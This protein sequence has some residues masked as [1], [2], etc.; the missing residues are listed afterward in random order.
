MIQPNLQPT[1]PRMGFFVTIVD[2]FKLSAIVI[3]SPIRKTEGVLDPLLV[4]LVQA[5]LRVFIIQ[6][7]QGELCNV[8]HSTHQVLICVTRTNAIFAEVIQVQ[9][10]RFVSQKLHLTWQYFSQVFWFLFFKLLNRITQLI[11]LPFSISCQ[12]QLFQNQ[13]QSLAVEIPYIVS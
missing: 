11:H 8:C 12:F 1:S 9:T 2:D 3:K 7:C 4:A 5:A 13:T 6:S 10:Q